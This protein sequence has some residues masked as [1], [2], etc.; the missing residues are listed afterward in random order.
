VTHTEPTQA[1]VCSMGTTW[2]VSWVI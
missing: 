1:A 2:S